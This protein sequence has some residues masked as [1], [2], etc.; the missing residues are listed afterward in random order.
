MHGRTNPGAPMN[1][2]NAW[3]HGYRTVETRRVRAFLTALNR[4]NS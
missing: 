2:H 1:I 3:K 4:S